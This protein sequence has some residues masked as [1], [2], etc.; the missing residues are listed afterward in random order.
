MIRYGNAPHVGGQLLFL[1]SGQK[2][3]A[4]ADLNHRLEYKDLAVLLRL[5]EREFKG[6]GKCYVAFS[7]TRL[8]LERHHIDMPAQHEFH[9]AVLIDISGFHS[10]WVVLIVDLYPCTL[11][12]ELVLMVPPKTV[13]DLFIFMSDKARIVLRQGLERFRILVLLALDPLTVKPDPEHPV[14]RD[15][16]GLQGSEILLGIGKCV[17]Y[18]L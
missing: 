2:A 8:R 15:N 3:Q 17:T 6:T 18:V 1:V 13:C 14:I 12:P 10:P 16:D 9:G 5:L 7:E 11:E 4:F